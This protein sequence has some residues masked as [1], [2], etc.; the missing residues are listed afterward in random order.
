MPVRQLPWRVGWIR[1]T[2]AYR[3]SKVRTLGRL[4]AW[5]ARELLSSR[6]AFTYDGLKFRTMRNNF[7]GLYSFV[8]GEYEPELLRFLRDSLAPGQVFI[9]VGGNI[10]LY[11]ALAAR[12][13]G[14]GGRVVVFEGHP[15]IAAMLRENM[16]LNRLANVEVVSAAVGAAP[17]KTMM[18]LETG[19]SGASHV[20]NSNEPG[21]VEVDVVT[22]DAALAKFGIDH[23]DYIKIDVEG[24]EEFALTGA[25]ETIANND[26]VTIQIEVDKRWLERYGSS[27][28]RIFEILRGHGLTPHRLDDANALVAID[29]QD[30]GDIIWRRAAAA[31]DPR[32]PANRR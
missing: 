25:A 3:R 27:P 15:A 12:R 30:Y 10:G 19:N 26:A 14:K 8:A 32:R 24:F 23:V 1:T 18:K 17:A 28:S 21:N 22:I 5:T 11:S 6:L 16:A 2:A 29:D 9:D 4:A 7:V 20:S 31:G 13:V